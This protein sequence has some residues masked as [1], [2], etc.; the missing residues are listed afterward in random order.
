MFKVELAEF[1]TFTTNRFH[2][3]AN[4]KY[5]SNFLKK[6]PQKVTNAMF[7]KRTQLT[8]TICRIPGEERSTDRD[9]WRETWRERVGRRVREIRR[10]NASQGESER[11]REARRERLREG[12]RKR[13]RDIEREAL[14]FDISFWRAEQIITQTYCLSDVSMCIATHAAKPLSDV[15]LDIL[16]LAALAGPLLAATVAHVNRQV[17]SHNL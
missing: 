14:F 3:R 8:Q 17:G 7:V 15:E 9:T 6:L 1:T 5:R 13:Q 11:E 12:V 4:I 2:G 16:S 10:E